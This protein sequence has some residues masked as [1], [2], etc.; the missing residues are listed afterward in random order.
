MQHALRT[1]HSRPCVR[2]L[3]HLSPARWL[4]PCPTWRARRPTAARLPPEPRAR[5]RAQ[6][7]EASCWIP[8]LRGKKLVLAGDHCQLPPTITSR[9][10][11]KGGLGRT[12]FD[13]AR[14]MHPACVHMLEVQYRMHQDISGWSSGA[15]YAN[16]LQSA[17][18]VQVRAWGGGWS[19]IAA[20]G[21]R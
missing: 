11:E 7:L 2:R 16:R 21:V 8:I 1:Q 12:L 15:M 9:E 10:A 18:E 20:G 4:G 6:A 17:E 5:P 19:G 3:R 14:A 13:R